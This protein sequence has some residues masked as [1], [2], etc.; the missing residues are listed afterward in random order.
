MSQQWTPR[1]S[2]T[3]GNGATWQCPTW[4]ESHVAVLPR[5][6]G[7][8][9]AVLGGS[10]FSKSCLFGNGIKML[11]KLLP[12]LAMATPKILTVENRCHC[13]FSACCNNLWASG[14]VFVML[15]KAIY[16]VVCFVIIKCRIYVCIFSSHKLGE[17]VRNQ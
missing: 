10:L 11:H 3:R 9:Q 13:T 16:G 12:F 4:P 7:T 6:S 14:N 17:I 1:G 5:G 15:L 2:R 8:H